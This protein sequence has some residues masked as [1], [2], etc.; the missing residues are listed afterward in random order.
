MKKSFQLIALLLSLS[1][2]AQAAG[3]S[4]SS[5]SV[6]NRVPIEIQKVSYKELK[7]GK[8]LIVVNWAFEGGGG[9][10]ITI[11]KL[12]IDLELTDAKGFKQKITRTLTNQRGGSGAVS[13]TP[14][15]IPRDA[16]VGVPITSLFR[17][18][19]DPRDE[20]LPVLKFKVTLTATAIN[21]EDEIAKGPSS[22]RRTLTGV[23]HK[24][25]TIRVSR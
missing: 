9:V 19:I 22:A 13:I 7:D 24:E 12:T 10:G 11:T 6:T 14:I 25:G 15:P 16:L 23:A 17:G 3:L 2:V 5:G 1:S 8:H 4:S 21:D 20:T 18:F